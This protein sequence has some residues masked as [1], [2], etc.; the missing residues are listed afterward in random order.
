MLAE[1]Q[2][3]AQLAE[4]QAVLLDVDRLTLRV[5]SAPEIQQLPAC[6]AEELKSLQQM[7]HRLAIEHN[8]PPIGEAI[9]NA[10]DL[11]E[12]VARYGFRLEHPLV[13]TAWADF[14]TS[15]S[16]VFAD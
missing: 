3:E 9:Q 16:E 5:L 12:V 15:L 1:L 6:L 8:G 13:A 4:A 11:R 14:C 10:Q 7:A 2:A